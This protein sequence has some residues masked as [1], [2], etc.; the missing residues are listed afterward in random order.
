MA[1]VHLLLCH[2]KLAFRRHGYSR[3]V[4]I[5]LKVNSSESVKIG[6]DLLLFLN[7]LVLIKTRSDVLNIVT[8]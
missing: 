2:G 7:N 4:F 6:S 8:V 5:Q 1:L 3:K